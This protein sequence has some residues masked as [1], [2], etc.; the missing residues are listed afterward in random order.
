[1]RNAI[2]HVDPWSKSFVKMPII[3]VRVRSSATGPTNG[4][5]RT[6]RNDDNDDGSQVRRKA[7]ESDDRS[8]SKRLEVI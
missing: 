5:R 6:D 1:M 4:S 8:S 3:L 7:M 2:G